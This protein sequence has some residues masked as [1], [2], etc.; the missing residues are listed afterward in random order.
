MITGSHTN[1]PAQMPPNNTG[2][3]ALARSADYF[4][5]EFQPFASGIEKVEDLILATRHSD[6]IP[7]SADT[8]LITDIDLGILGA[9][10]PRYQMYAEDI[11][12]EYQHV[13]DDAYR[14][15]RSEVLRSFL[16]RKTIYNTRHFCKLLDAQARVNILQELENLNP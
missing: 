5:R 3:T 16:A 4:R 12:R 13:E 8:A 1:A 15:G 2:I 7:D 14:A 6:A 10:A 11:R 9:P